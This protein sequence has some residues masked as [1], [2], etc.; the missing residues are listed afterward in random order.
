MSS[1]RLSNLFHADGRGGVRWGLWSPAPRALCWR[2]ITANRVVQ[3]TER[4]WQFKVIEWAWR[5]IPV[6][7]DKGDSVEESANCNQW[8]TWWQFLTFTPLWIHK[9]VRIISKQQRKWCPSFISFSN[10]CFFCPDSGKHWTRLHGF[11]SILCHNLD[12][13]F[14]LLSQGALS[15]KPYR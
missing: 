12:L 3:L 7:I 11:K 15:I 8:L 6:R 4:Q 14:T 1:L 5:S 9:R 2:E 13:A 10:S